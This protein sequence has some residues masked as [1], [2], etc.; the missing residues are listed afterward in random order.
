MLY[1]SISQHVLV[2]TV[3]HPSQHLTVYLVLLVYLGIVL[4]YSK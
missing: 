2:V 1:M 3:Q 4:V